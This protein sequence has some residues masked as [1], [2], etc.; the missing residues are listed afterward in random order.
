VID[1]DEFKQVNDT[2]GHKAGDDTLK[3][4]RAGADPPG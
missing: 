3:A 1:L 4:V 2:Y